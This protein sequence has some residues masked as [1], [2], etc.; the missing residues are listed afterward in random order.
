MKDRTVLAIIC[1]LCIAVIEVVNLLTAHIDSTVI[2]AVVGA[3]ASIAGFKF[4]Q[5]T[6][7]S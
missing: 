2:A 3:I 5:R 4:G 7:H 1:V 6:A